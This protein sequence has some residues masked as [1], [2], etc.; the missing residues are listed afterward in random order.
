MYPE[1]FCIGIQPVGEIDKI[2]PKV[3]AGSF[4]GE[5]KITT[6]ELPPLE[7]PAYAFDKRRI[8]YDAGLILHEL[9]KLEWQGCTKIIAI[10][11]SDLFIPVFSYVLGEATIGGRCA[12]VSLFRLKQNPERAVKVALHEFGHLMNLGHCNEKGC[13]MNFSKNIEQLDLI[14]TYFC[15]YC[16][17][18]IR[19]KLKN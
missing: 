3:I 18:N 5:L 9:E 13:V 1:N 11:D 2:T 15:K 12:L 6:V 8:Q 10:I 16:Q 19:Y 7:H 17:D 4:L 14:S